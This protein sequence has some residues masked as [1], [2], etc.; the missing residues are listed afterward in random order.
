MG[1]A[2]WPAALHVL[3]SGGLVCA[4][5]AL[6]RLIRKPGV[7]CGETLAWLQ[8]TSLWGG[9]TGRAVPP[10]SPW[11]PREPGGQRGLPG[12]QLLEGVAKA[13]CLV[14]MFHS[15]LGDSAG[16]PS[17][18]LNETPH[19]SLC[20]ECVR[21]STCQQGSLFVVTGPVWDT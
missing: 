19:H 5:R 11:S 12:H 14:R 20:M 13:E 2:L 7:G 15:S 4:G 16:T 18:A 17:A 21:P 9:K 1:T 6:L 3:S 8:V 10:Q